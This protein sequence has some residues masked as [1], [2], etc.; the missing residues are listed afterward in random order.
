MAHRYGHPIVVSL[1]TNSLPA[2]MRW[3]NVEY[4]V[5]EVLSHWR[6]RD[7]W[8]APSGLSNAAHAISSA[9]LAS[10]RHYY[11]VRCTADLLCDIYY[12]AASDRW[13]LDRIHD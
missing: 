9:D 3:R 8:W 10:D 4:R 1:A 6:L 7:R 5:L 12:D 11:R 2:V 13:I